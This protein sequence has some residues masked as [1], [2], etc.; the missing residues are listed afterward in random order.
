MLG[1]AAHK[2]GQQIQDR[3]EDN[4]MND[5]NGQ[6][7][8]ATAKWRNVGN[9]IINTNNITTIRR[10]GKASS[11]EIKLTNG[12]CLTFQLI[13]R[14]SLRQLSLRQQKSAAISRATI[15]PNN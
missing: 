4:R 6:T 9:V 13:L 2:Y 3:L 14:S 10:V 8:G 11:T 15:S 12:M 5:E 1:I 7:G